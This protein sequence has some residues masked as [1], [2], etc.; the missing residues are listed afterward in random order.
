MLKIIF[1]LLTFLFL[2]YSSVVYAELNPLLQ[3]SSKYDKVRVERALTVDTILLAGGERVVLIG[4]QGPNPPKFRD[5]KRDQ[6]GFIIPDDDPTTTFELEA[7]RFVR[8]LVENKQ[9]HIE[10]DAER[11]DEDGV[12][13]AYVFLPDGKMLNE[14]AVR[15]GYARLQLRMPNMKYAQRLRE[16]YKES[17]H[18]MRGLQGNW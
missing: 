18:E 11:R 2:A 13:Q 15:F 1:V 16:A 6:N 17:R 14:E 7:L 4:I 12:L 3:S 10:F 9:V 8:G 5:V